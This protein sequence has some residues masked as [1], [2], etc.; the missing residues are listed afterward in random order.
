MN[1]E[2]HRHRNINPFDQKQ[3]HKLDVFRIGLEVIE[4]GIDPTGK[5]F[6]I[7]LTFEMLDTIISTIAHQRMDGLV[8]DSTIDTPPIG[9]SEPAGRNV[10][11]AAR[12]LLRWA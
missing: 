12:R 3:E 8:G 10:F 1:G 9:A 7:C 5:D 6:G 2:A 11:L 4:W